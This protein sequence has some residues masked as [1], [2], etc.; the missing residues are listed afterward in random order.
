MRCH[1]SDVEPYH[2]CSNKLD[3]CGLAGPSRAIEL[4]QD[5]QKHG[6]ARKRFRYGKKMIHVPYSNHAPSLESGVGGLTGHRGKGAAGLEEKARGLKHVNEKWSDSISSVF[7]SSFLPS[8]LSEQDKRDLLGKCQFGTGK[9]KVLPA[10]WQQVRSKSTGHKYYWRGQTGES[11]WSPPPSLA[12]H[13][14]PT[15]RPLTAPLPP[16]RAYQLDR[17]MPVDEIM[18]TGVHHRNIA[19]GS[20]TKPQLPRHGDL[21]ALQGEFLGSRSYGRGGPLRQI[22]GEARV[23]AL[24]KDVQK[25]VRTMRH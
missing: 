10:G 9:E 20:H 25:A 21:L 11:R 2:F 24:V 17:G 7:A 5:A 18:H 3:F 19:R 13:Y 12:E 22:D 14:L 23:A 4:L 8:S 6:G 15:T 1:C 16:S